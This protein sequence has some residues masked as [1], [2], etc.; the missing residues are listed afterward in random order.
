VLDP[1]QSFFGKGI[2]MNQ[3]AIRAQSSTPLSPSANSMAVRRYSFIRHIGKTRRDRAIYAGTY[4]EGTVLMHI[5][6]DPGLSGAVVVLVPCMR[7]P[8]DARACPV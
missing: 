2:N 8:R 5:G 3:A 7:H 1:V 6:I 4:S